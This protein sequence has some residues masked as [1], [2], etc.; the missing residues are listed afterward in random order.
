M[1]QVTILFLIAIN[2]EIIQK[3]YGR[4]VKLYLHILSK[5]EKKY[6]IYHKRVYDLHSRSK[7]YRFGQNNSIPQ[8]SNYALA[9]S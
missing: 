6:F 3:R 9:P 5:G 4:F 1:Y 2:G 8:D 7:G